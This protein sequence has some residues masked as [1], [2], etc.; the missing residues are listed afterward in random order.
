MLIF[1]P[2]WPAAIGSPPS[3][4]SDGHA[5][6]PPWNTS[7]PLMWP[8]IRAEITGVANTAFEGSKRLGAS[9]LGRRP[10]IPLTVVAREPSVSIPTVEQ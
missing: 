5:T 3:A 8:Q 1:M 10:L 9:A 7:P 2:A 4:G 6:R